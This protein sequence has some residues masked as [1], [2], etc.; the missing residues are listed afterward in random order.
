[1]IKA[2]QGHFQEGRFVSPQTAAIPEYVEV[3][4]VVT[5]KTVPATQ[6]N[7]NTQRQAIEEFT[8]TFTGNE[9]LGDAISKITS[10]NQGAKKNPRI[11]RD[12]EPNKPSLLGCMEGLVKIPDDFDEPLEEMKEYM[13]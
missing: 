7:L 6:A 8:R 12:Y 1:M 11:L 9:S 5:D 13:Y 2:F 4:I 10:Q 3:F